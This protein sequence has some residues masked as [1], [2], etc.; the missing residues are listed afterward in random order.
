MQFSPLKLVT[1]ISLLF[2]IFSLFPATSLASSFNPNNLIS[3]EELTDTSTMSLG[4]I[5]TF[6]NRGFLGNY[7]TEDIDGKNRYASAVIWRAATRNGINPK[8]ILVMLQKEQSLVL[9][10][11]PSQSQLDWAMGYAVCDSCNH[12]DPNIQR[13]KGLA[14]QVNSSTLQLVEGYLADLQSN[15]ETVAGYAPGRT[16][17]ID[18]TIVTPANNATAAL[19]T[20]TPHIHGNSN[21]VKLWQD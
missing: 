3:D 5:Q 6:L 1:K 17:T 21:F 8:V 20:Y 18:N 11:S 13:W 9:D 7:V 4:E 19:Y 12:R 15:G 10:D 16:T 14:K 2:L